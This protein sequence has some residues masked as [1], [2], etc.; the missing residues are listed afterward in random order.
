MTSAKSIMRIQG[1]ALILALLSA[2]GTTKTAV[3]N[4]WGTRSKAVSNKVYTGAWEFHSTTKGDG[5]VVRLYREDFL[6][7]TYDGRSFYEIAF[8]LPA[9]AAAGDSF[10]LNPIPE[11]RS[12]RRDGKFHRLAEMH[13]GE[14]AAMRFGNPSMGWMK[15]AERATV[16]IVSIGNHKVVIH[17]MLKAKLDPDF[18]FDIDRRFV[19][20]VTEST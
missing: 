3:E 6:V 8:V 15:S 7:G 9:T 12:F 14:I 4:S 2:C 16:H 10:A 20:Q 19:L 5:I 1:L 11:G 17:L 18:D 13:P